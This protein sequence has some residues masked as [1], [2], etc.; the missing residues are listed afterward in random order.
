MD[1]VTDYANWKFENFSLLDKLVKLNS[2][3]IKR[4]PHVILV[5]DYYYDKV[6]NNGYQLNREEETIFNA[7]FNYLYDHFSTLSLL[8]ERDFNNNIEELNKVGKTINLLIYTNDFQVEIENVDPNNTKAKKDLADF[9]S[10]VLG[11]IETHTN[12]P[13]EM[14]A[15]LSDITTP[16]FDGN[17]YGVNEILYDV[18]EELG[19]A[20]DESDTD[21][22]TFT[23]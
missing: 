22:Y 9:E 4:F 13:D 10:K 5:C 15:V 2:D 18:A 19:I 14:F 7:G 23:Y 11:Y 3:I 16:I 1:I 17:Y 21:E 6:T 12:A 8:L 20:P